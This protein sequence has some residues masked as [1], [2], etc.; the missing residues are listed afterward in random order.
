MDR[1]QARVALSQGI[2]TPD[3]TGSLVVCEET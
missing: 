1:A 2:E 3:A